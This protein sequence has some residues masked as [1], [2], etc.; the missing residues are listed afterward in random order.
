MSDLANCP[1][2]GTE[3]KSGMFKKSVTLY[4]KNQIELM[5]YFR[6]DDASAYCSEC[7]GLTYAE[8]A[9]KLRKTITETTINLQK[10]IGHIPVLTTHNPQGW[11]YESI[12]MVTAQST[13]GTGVIT[14]F[15]SDFTDILGAKSKRH[16]TKLKKGEDVCL[17]QLR[18]SAY[19]LGANAIIATDI[20][21][22]ELGSGRG[23][24]MICMAGTAVKVKDTSVF[25]ETRN[26]KLLALES[27]M[28][29]M[30]ELN[31]FLPKLDFVMQF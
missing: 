16:N 27:M 22:A 18:N 19:D 31:S 3:L 8:A 30:K 15:V 12:E 9:L 2:C 17:T 21:Y 25:G 7:E 23:I 14:E 10:L 4:T 26:K 20:D 13:T 1:N 6:N 11:D 28:K 5:R 29:K 24:L